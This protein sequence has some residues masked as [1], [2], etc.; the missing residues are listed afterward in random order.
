M[1]K[2]R[3]FKFLKNKPFFNYY[4]MIT[5]ES[6]KEYKETDNNI[7]LYNSKLFSHNLKIKI[8]KNLNLN[9]IKQIKIK[10]NSNK[11]K[12][13]IFLPNISKSNIH[14]SNKYN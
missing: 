8:A 3:S 1:I 2:S 13:K 6:K 9:N 12:L 4:T 11:K 10:A 5:E 7:N 14:L